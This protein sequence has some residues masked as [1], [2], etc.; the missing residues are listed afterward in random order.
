MT[1]NSNGQRHTFNMIDDIRT[2]FW[3]ISQDSSVNGSGFRYILNDTTKHPHWHNDNN[4]KFW[5]NYTND[6]IKNGV[7]RLGGLL[8]D[9]KATNYPNLP[10]VVTVKTT[11][12]AHADSFGYDRGYTDRQWIGDLGELLVFNEALEDHEIESIEGYLA[13]KW[14]LE[15]S[16]TAGHSYKTNP[17]AQEFG[18]PFTFGNGQELEKLHYD[19]LHYLPAY[20]ENDLISRWDFEGST[21]DP[22]GKTR[23]IDL[24][25]GK[26]D[27]FLEG[28]AHLSSGRFGKALRLDG[29]GDFLS[30][31][32]FR[33]GYNSRN[34]T[35]SAWIKLLNSG[36]SE[37][38][39]D[40]SIFSTDGSSTNHAR[41]WYDINA[42]GI[43]NRTYSFILG[44][45]L[46][47]SNRASGTDGLGIA[48]QWQFIVWVMDQDRAPSMSMAI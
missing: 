33:G 26:N 8:I 30:L 19:V 45:T 2:A 24:G 23:I 42:N 14:G 15:G 40:A 47:Q 22:N 32:K 10:S 38:S 11:G 39:D 3:V 12:D 5:G 18:Q 21:V 31:P 7:T 16:L 44:S 43:G 13:H 9:G 20:R 4:G 34:L 46:A 25:P 29:S 48:N 35:F 1:Y 36:S 41:L 37:D 28:N 27:G 6:V 17:P